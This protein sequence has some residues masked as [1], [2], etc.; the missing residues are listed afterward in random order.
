MPYHLPG[1]KDRVAIVTGHKTGIGASVFSLLEKQGAKVYGFDLPEFDLSET[2][3]IPSYVDKVAKAEKGCIDIL[4]N[5]AG[6]TMLGDLLE[7]EPEDVDNVLAVNFKAPFF[8]MKAVIPYMLKQKR[9]VIVNNASDQAFVG[10]RYS[11]IYGASKAAVAQLT[12]S[13]SL[14]WGPQGIRVNCVAPGSTDTP[15][16]RRVIKDLHER[17]P[18]SFP[19][20]SESFYK[21][22]VP[23]KRFADP[24]EIAW[25]MVFLASDAASFITG[26]VIPVDGGFIAQ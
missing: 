13:A 6:I 18:Q 4:I 17:Y 16:L 25:A 12:K 8:M 22:S 7:T 23:L 19:T 2:A 24:A 26:A 15:M 21:D 9:G 20:N 5:N 1:I 14:D 3:S 10:K 11:A